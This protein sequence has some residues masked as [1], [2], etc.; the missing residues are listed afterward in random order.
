MTVMSTSLD[1]GII[2]LV[3]REAQIFNDRMIKL[4]RLREL[5]EGDREFITM[6]LDDL[7]EILQIL[8]EFDPLPTIALRNLSE[9]CF[10]ESNRRLRGLGFS[11]QEALSS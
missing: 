1:E 10:T 9:R 4:N 11:V 2:Q 3:E 8:R 5:V 7:Q 6:P